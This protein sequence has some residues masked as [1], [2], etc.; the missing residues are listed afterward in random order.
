MTF[1]CMIWHIY[2]SIY[3]LCKWT[4]VLLV[5]EIPFL[6]NFNS[7][8]WHYCQDEMSSFQ[9]SSPSCLQFILKN[10][11]TTLDHVTF[12]NILSL[13]LFCA[14]KY[15]WINNKVLFIHLII[16]TCDKILRYE[17]AVASNKVPD[18]ISVC[19]LLK[20]EDGNTRHLLIVLIDLPVERR[21]IIGYLNVLWIKCLSQR[22]GLCNQKVRNI[23]TQNTAV[24]QV[25]HTIR[26][27]LSHIETF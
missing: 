20:P 17:V 10:N 4:A 27:C 11:P 18:L 15:K 23:F 19:G 14:A 6:W 22:A 8:C 5:S 3:L 7:R 2:L 26:C 21:N 9:Y 16:F 12:I 13:P 25:L 24:M 1:V